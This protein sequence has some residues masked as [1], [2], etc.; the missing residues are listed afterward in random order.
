M[1]MISE[2]ITFNRKIGLPYHYL[3]IFLPIAMK[4][5]AMKNVNAY[6]LL[7]SSFFP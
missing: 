6:A 1:V 3:D 2:L 7:G 4:I 5:S